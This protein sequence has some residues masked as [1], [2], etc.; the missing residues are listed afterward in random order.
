MLTHRRRDRLV[1]VSWCLI[2]AVIWV[3]AIYGATWLRHAYEVEPTLVRNTAIVAC[4]AAMGH[5]LASFLTGPYRKG[6]VRGSFE[7]VLEVAATVAIVCAG[8]MAWALAAR[9]IVVP[10]TVPVMAALI[11]S[12]AMMAIRFVIRAARQRHWATLEGK[13][14]I[15]VFGAGNGGRLLIRNLRHDPTSPYIPVALLDDD[16][17]KRRRS[18][19]GVRVRGG[20][21]H[22][23][24]AA[25]AYDAEK[26]VIAIPSANAETIRELRQAAAE[27]GVKPLVV[28]TMSA[29]VGR[30]P[31]SHDIRDV[32][33]EDLLG[34]RPVTLDQAAIASELDSRTVLVTGA[35][36]SIGSELCRQIANFHPSKLVMLDR[37]ESA[38]QSV[39]LDLDGHG[40]LESDSIVLADI[41]DQEAMHRVFQ[42]HRPDVVFHAAALKHLPLLER[43]PL[44]AWKTNVLG[45]LNV[46]RAAQGSGVGTFVNISTDKAADPVCVLG[47]SKRIAERLT[48]DMAQH[49]PG[50]YLSVRFGNVLGSRGSVIPAFTRQITKGGPVTVTHRDVQRYFMLIPEACQLV[51]QAAVMGHAGEV[52][53][54]D[55]GTPVRIREIAE[56]LIA[57]SG[58]DD[59]EVVYTGLRPGEKMSEDLFNAADRSR[60]TTHRLVTSVD[61]PALDG[62]TVDGMPLTHERAAGWMRGCAREGR[63]PV[64]TLRPVR[65]AQP[66]DAS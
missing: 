15:L 3:V 29:M 37:D 21:D 56:T 46:L 13:E 2:D 18:F 38:L 9:P 20:R 63:G 4:A 14:R 6:H 35:G 47:Y 43:Y 52:M 27:A 65:D 60:A 31:T 10:R 12:L 61:V 55:M 48:A 53:V 58:R 36:G 64:P 62:N 16:R 7:E 40:L 51:M 44:E 32:N 34:R 57:M 1:R 28:P 45:T 5:V 33:L 26:M 19:D 66:S 50:R 25:E 30:T 49:A 22:I 42:Q 11:A 8:L 59:I 54:L 17:G 24:K 39:Q 41:R 23:A